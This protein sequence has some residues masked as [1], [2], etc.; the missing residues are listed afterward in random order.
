MS[1]HPNLGMGRGL[2]WNR[3]PKAPSTTHTD[4]CPKSTLTHTNAADKTQTAPVP[5]TKPRYAPGIGRGLILQ[6]S[7]LSRP[8]GPPSDTRSGEANRSRLYVPVASVIRAL[9]GIQEQLFRTQSYVRH[10]DPRLLSAIKAT[11][12]CVDDA[13]VGLME[14]GKPLP[15]RSE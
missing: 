11:R 7:D 2:P 9:A 10:Y 14:E 12:T 15:P 6:P 4:T 13:A 1:G 5:A 8:G 3:P